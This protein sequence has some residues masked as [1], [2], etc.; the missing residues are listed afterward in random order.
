MKN[1]LKELILQFIANNKNISI[2]I[3]ADLQGGPLVTIQID[4]EEKGE[5]YNWNH[6]KGE[7][8]RV[9]LG[10]S[11]ELELVEL[12]NDWTEKL[13]EFLDSEAI[14]AGQY[15]IFM[16]QVGDKQ[17]F[18]IEVPVEDEW[19]EDEDEECFEEWIYDLEEVMNI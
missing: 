15:Y 19:N 13:Y 18:K 7:H 2:V 16:G 14:L 4:G 12:F 6:K 5:K 3:D 10:N 11:I 9:K 8:E 1:R 17:I